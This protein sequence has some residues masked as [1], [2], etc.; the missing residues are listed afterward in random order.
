PGVLSIRSRERLDRE[1]PGKARAGRRDDQGHADTTLRSKGDAKNRRSLPAGLRAWP[2]RASR[3]LRKC[4]RKPGPPD[5]DQSRTLAPD[6]SAGTAGGS[7][8]GC[9]IVGIRRVRA[10]QVGDAWHVS[11]VLLIENE[12]KASRLLLDD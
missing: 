3:R 2:H 4:A 7:C 1:E 5:C 11:R 6:A 8:R 9:L 10:K 12:P